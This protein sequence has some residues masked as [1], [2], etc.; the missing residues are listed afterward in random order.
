MR[1]LREAAF[2]ATAPKATMYVWVPVPAGESSQAF[3]TR[4]LEQEGV[5]IMPGRALGAGGE[6][7]FRIALTVSEERML[8]ATQRLGRVQLA[9]ASRNG[10]QRAV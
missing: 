4:A 6:G 3:A 2:D 1:G 9:S 5:I 10:A 8:E 7:F